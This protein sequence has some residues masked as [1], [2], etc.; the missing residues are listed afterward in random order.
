MKLQILVIVLFVFAFSGLA[1][2]TIDLLNIAGS[3]DL[4]QQADAIR[5][6]THVCSI[7]TMLSC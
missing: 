1:M 7:P 5:R 6:S 3:D 2:Y 4:I